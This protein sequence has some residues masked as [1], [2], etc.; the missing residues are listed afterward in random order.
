MTPLPAVSLTSNDCELLRNWA[1]LNFELDEGEDLHD[2]I[3][4]NED[5]ID[6]NN[7]DEGQDE[8]DESSDEDVDI[9]AD[10]NTSQGQLTFSLEQDRGM[11]GRSGLIIDCCFT[12]C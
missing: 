9:S 8:F 6:G 11:E 12:L 4:S 1:S 5:A 3:D 7:P 2:D 10:D